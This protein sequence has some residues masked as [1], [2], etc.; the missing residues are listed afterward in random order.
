[1]LDFSIVGDVRVGEYIDERVGVSRVAIQNWIRRAAGITATLCERHPQRPLECDDCVR[2]T[3]SHAHAEDLLC[4]IIGVAIGVD[5]LNQDSSG[6]SGAARD[7]RSG[8]VKRH[9]LSC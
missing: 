7:L 1:M 5:D 8:A 2:L 6:N 4:D 3:F 9:G